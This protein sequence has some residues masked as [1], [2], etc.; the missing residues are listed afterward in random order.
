M[1]SLS[2]RPTSRGDQAV[3]DA[4]RNIAIMTGHVRITRPDGTQL[5]GDVGEVDFTNNQSRLLNEGKGT[6]VRALLTSK[7]TDKTAIKQARPVSKPAA[8]PANP[9]P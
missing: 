7:S 3:Y 2:P 9:L 1:S 5:T 4:N 8:H 6:R